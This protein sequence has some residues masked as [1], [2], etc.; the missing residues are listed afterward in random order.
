MVKLEFFFFF[1]FLEVSSFIENT[2]DFPWFENSPLFQ[3]TALTLKLAGLP[4]LQLFY[5]L[6]LFYFIF[7]SHVRPNRLK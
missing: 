7:I 3:V 1:F 5:I 2:Y 4:S 6:F